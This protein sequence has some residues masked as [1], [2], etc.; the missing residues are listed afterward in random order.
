PSRQDLDRLTLTMDQAPLAQQLR[1]HH[2][3]G[4]EALG[5]HVEVHDGILH[6]EGIVES[7]LWNTTMERHL[8]AFESALELVAR[9]RLRTLGAASGLRALACSVTAADALLVS[10]HALGGLEIAQIH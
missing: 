10:L 2:R 5:Q 4:I 1:C 9:A 8:A 7:P 3:A 6:A